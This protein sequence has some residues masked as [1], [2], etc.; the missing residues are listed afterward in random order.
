[1]L[2]TAPAPQAADLLTGCADILSDEFL[3]QLQNVVYDP[4]FSLLLTLDGPSHVPSPGYVRPEGGPVE[5][6]AD[7]TQKGV[8]SAEGAAL[9]IHAEAAFSREY[10]DADKKHVTQL[11]LDAA[12][13]F[14]GALVTAS[15]LHRWKFSRPIPAERPMFLDAEVPAHLV[16]AGD[17]FGGPRVEGAFLSGL[18]AAERMIAAG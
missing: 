17:A 4:C 8:S 15:Q 11:L 10:F 13:P 14:I 1:L 9:T 18:G 6:I 12:E 5:W 2:I 3:G 7:N 16:V